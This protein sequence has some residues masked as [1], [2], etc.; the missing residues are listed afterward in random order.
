LMEAR[1]GDPVAVEAV[2]AYCSAMCTK[3]YNSFPEC[4]EVLRTANGEF[5][6]IRKR[7]TLE[8]ILANEIPLD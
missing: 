1:I 3:N 2:G 5:R 7:Q 8:Q 6:L 4:A